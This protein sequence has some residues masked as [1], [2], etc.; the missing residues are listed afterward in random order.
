MH[1]AHQHILG[2]SLRLVSLLRGSTSALWN[3]AQPCTLETRGLNLS[4]IC[5]NSRTTCSSEGHESNLVMPHS[6]HT[7][8]RAELVPNRKEAPDS[9][10][11]GSISLLWQLAAL[12]APKTYYTMATFELLSQPIPHNSFSAFGR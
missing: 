4:V 10:M 9:L 2:K 11:L 8:V 12:S 1:Q 6:T 5:S 3:Y 7:C